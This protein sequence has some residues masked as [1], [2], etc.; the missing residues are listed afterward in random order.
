M[1]TVIEDRRAAL[2]RIRGAGSELVAIKRLS[3]R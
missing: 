3:L 2:T 1:S